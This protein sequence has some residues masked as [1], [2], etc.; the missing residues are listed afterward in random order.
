MITTI[1]GDIIDDRTIVFI[2][3]ISVRYS[4]PL[5]TKSRKINSVSKI[6]FLSW[7]GKDITSD[8]NEY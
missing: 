3:E 6:S 2:G 4:S 7:V 8:I 5:I 1:V